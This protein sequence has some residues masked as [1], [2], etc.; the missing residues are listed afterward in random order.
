MCVCLCVCVCAR[1]RAC[2]WMVLGCVIDTT[3]N[4]T[5][6]YGDDLILLSPSVSGLSELIQVCV[7]YWLNHEMKY[8]SQKV[9]C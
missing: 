9:L 6:M 5:L 7:L 1:A 3:T 2:V 4:N 8:N